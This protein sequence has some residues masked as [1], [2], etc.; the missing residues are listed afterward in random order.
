MQM[1]RKTWAAAGVILIGLAG[2]TAEADGSPGDKAGGSSPVVTLT[3][4]TA[5][6]QGR[7]D[8]PAVEYFVDRLEAL[9]KGSVTVDVHWNA[10]DE[11]VDGERGVATAVR[12]GGLDLGW[13][14]SRT[15]DTLG[16]TSLR[17]VQ[18]P[19]LIT[20]N[21]LTR[22]VAQDQVARTMLAGLTRAKVVGLGLYPDELRHPV[23]FRGPL[24][25]MADFQGAQ[26][27]TPVSN[28]SDALFRA[29]GMEPVHP[30]GSASGATF[31]SRTLDGVDASLGRAADLGGSFVTGNVVFF[32]RMS[33]LFGSEATFAKLDRSQRSGLDRA[34]RESLEQAVK[35]LPDVEDPTPFCEGGGTVVAASDADLAA[36][37]RAAQPVYS[38]LEAD[39]ETKSAINA[40][41]ALARQVGPPPTPT[42]CGAP[43]PSNSSSDTVL[44]PDGTYTAV[45]TKADALRLG[46]Q[47]QC[48]LQA[49]GNHLRLELKK[50]EFAQWEKCSIVA[51]Q[52]GSHGDF[53]VT[54]DTFTII[55]ACCG[56]TYLDWA[57]D[58]QFLTLKQRAYE[59]GGPLDPTARLIM[60]HRWKKVS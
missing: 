57:F 6:P 42:S 33:V 5:D 28:T 34:A 8:T 38:E 12:S 10:A 46:A 50:G 27:R 3:L 36:M 60:D 24:A 31:D 53:T 32:P 9:T 29:L 43:R 26:F 17:A 44:V 11:Y 1:N 52:I 16:V 37:R 40:I 49:D 4:G 48:A 59:N 19:F 25:S 22:K 39:P 13:V 56:E 7:P 54:K 20:D 21:R 51:D 18:A 41:R 23:G 15:F 47:D 55:E 14:G 30:P 2:C 58:G 45:A 35:I